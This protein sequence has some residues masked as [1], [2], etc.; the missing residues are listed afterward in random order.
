LTDSHLRILEMAARNSQ[1]R[2]D[3]HDAAEGVA[4]AGFAERRHH[5][6]TR[7]TRTRARVAAALERRRH[8]PRS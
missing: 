4:T 3:E 6:K 5:L 7:A 2:L 8:A 1:R